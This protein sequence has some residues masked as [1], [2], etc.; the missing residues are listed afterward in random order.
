MISGTKFAARAAAALLAALVLAT[1]ASAQDID[2][3]GLMTMLASVESASATFVETRYSPLLKSPL[4]SRGT[5][6]YRRPDFLEEHVQSPA[7]ERLVLQG[8]QLTVESASGKRSVT[9]P[10]DSATGIAALI[11]GVRATRSGDLPA[12]ER[13]FD[14]QVTGSRERWRLRLLPRRADLAKYVE[15]IAIDGDADRMQRIEVSEASGDRTVM[16]IQ[17]TVH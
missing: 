7:D 12:L 13:N 1:A 9:V 4:V 6:S 3:R 14:V 10:A 15:E 16:D 2:A 8:A 11:E 5:L 17:E